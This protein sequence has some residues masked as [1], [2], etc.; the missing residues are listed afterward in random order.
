MYVHVGIGQEDT[1]K[2]DQSD[3]ESGLGTSLQTREKSILTDVCA[4]ISDSIAIF[5]LLYYF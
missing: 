4:S 2:F 1:T 3:D 5:K